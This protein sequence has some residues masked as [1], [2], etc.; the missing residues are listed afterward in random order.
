MS[1]P[2]L[3]SDVLRK[4]DEFED[5]VVIPGLL[6]EGDCSEYFF[7]VDT[8][9]KLI[10]EEQGVL[11]RS[12]VLRDMSTVTELGPISEAVSRKLIFTLSAQT[13]CW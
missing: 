6:S 12:G 8:L 11:W 2:L 4:L 1:H 9:E 5:L 10:C 3:L 13:L 7:H